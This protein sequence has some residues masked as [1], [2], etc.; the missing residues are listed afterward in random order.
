MADLMNDILGS[1]INAEIG[2]QYKN[3]A[4]KNEKLAQ[5]L[6]AARQL[7]YMQ[8]MASVLPSGTG[9]IDTYLTGAKQWGKKLLK[10]AP[11]QTSYDDLR[12]G[13]VAPK[14]GTG[15]AEEQRI[16][17]ADVLRYLKLIPT[18]WHSQEE[19][20]TKYGDILG[21]LGALV[22]E[23]SDQV[24]AAWDAGQKAYLLNKA[25]RQKMLEGKLNE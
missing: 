11:L 18:K 10:Q 3:K 19:E 20:A 15:I 14:I 17:D 6:A 13:L 25:L 22:G 12:A 8:Q 5:A 4:A 24:K 16:T 9:T 1:V 23:D 7:G 21:N 2:N